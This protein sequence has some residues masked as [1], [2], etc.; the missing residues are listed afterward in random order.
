MRQLEKVR[1]VAHG[2]A[3]CLRDIEQE[4]RDEQEQTE[5]LGR[6]FHDTHQ[7]LFVLK[8]Q[9]REGPGHYARL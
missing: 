4:L 2:Q 3:I 8:E 9:L 5:T 6:Q 1:G 7:H